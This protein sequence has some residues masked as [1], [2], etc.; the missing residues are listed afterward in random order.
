MLYPYTLE[1]CKMRKKSPEFSVKLEEGGLGFVK[2]EVFVEKYENRENCSI[3]ILTIEI[4]ISQP[5]L[6]LSFCHL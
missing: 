2:C 5:H 3:I 1:S 4:S 6:N